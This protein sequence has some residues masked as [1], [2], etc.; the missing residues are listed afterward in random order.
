MKK[1]VCVTLFFSIIAHANMPSPSARGE[2]PNPSA[3][4][5]R[6][7]FRSSSGDCDNDEY[8][9]IIKTKKGKKLGSYPKISF[10]SNPDLSGNPVLEVTDEGLLKNGNKMCDNMAFCK[11]DFFRFYTFRDNDVT[12]ANEVYF[13][14]DSYIRDKV[15]VATLGSA[16]VFADISSIDKEFEA[17][18][19]DS[20]GEFDRLCSFKKKNCNYYIVHPPGKLVYKEFIKS[21]PEVKA[22]ISYVVSCLDKKD[23]KCADEKSSVPGGISDYLENAF[24]TAELRQDFDKIK[25]NLEIPGL[26]DSL[27]S[28]LDDGIVNYRSQTVPPPNSLNSFLMKTD[29]IRMCSSKQWKISSD[30]NADVCCIIEVAKMKD[31][32]GVIKTEVQGIRYYGG[33]E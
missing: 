4:K 13:E 31:E 15:I 24:S 17:K 7:V 18:D 10:F 8:R 9:K 1:I 22:V 2:Y 29:R 33:A 30:L 12:Y 6:I 5:Y 26:V 3:D 27:K 28:C 14:F 32:K 19:Y 25:N 16:K 20:W 23:I 21:Y 11:N